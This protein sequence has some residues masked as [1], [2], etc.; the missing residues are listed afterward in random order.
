MEALTLSS[1]RSVPL[2]DR[3]LFNLMFFLQHY[4][5]ENES[6]R[7]TKEASRQRAAAHVRRGGPG[8]VVPVDRVPNTI[9]PEDFRRRYLSKGVPC[10]IENGIAGWPRQKNWTF[11]NF[12]SKFGESTIKLT[13]RKGLSDDDW[14]DETEYTEE[15]V[16]GDFLRNVLANGRTYMRFAPLLEQ[17]PELLDDFDQGFFRR[18]TGHTWGLTY[19]LFIGGKGSYTP[20]HNAIT[21]F[22]FANACGTKR[23]AL[24]PCKY[25][26]LIN[27]STDGFGYNHSEAQVTGKIDDRFPGFE[28]IDRM[29]AVLQPGDVYF[30]PPWMWHAVENDSPTIGVRCGFVHPKGMV[31]AS[32]TLTMT[33]IFAARNPSLFEAF[34]HSLSAHGL[35]LKDVLTL[36]PK[37]LET[38]TTR[39]YTKPVKPGDRERSLE[40]S[41]TPARVE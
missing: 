34:R 8:K 14:V 10:I 39:L 16:F 30:N 29:E 37:L 38:M 17:F 27:P 28:S 36:S 23:W 40:S 20:L 18:M 19:Q 25:L 7:S 6:I 31:A 3:G 26:P 35:K 41:S 33:R 21:P 5:P 32:V 4:F 2:R 9:S 11:D 15:V 13:Q 22:F 24:I 12:I 1:L